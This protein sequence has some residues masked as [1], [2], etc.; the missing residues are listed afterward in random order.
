MGINYSKVSNRVLQE[1]AFDP[2]MLGKTEAIMSLGNGYMGVRSATE[3]RYLRETRASLWPEP[4][5]NLTR[6]K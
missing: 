6:T 2:Q 1:D 5:T 4:L 3:D